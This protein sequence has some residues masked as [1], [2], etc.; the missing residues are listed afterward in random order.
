MQSLVA[1]L[2]AVVPWRARS[3]LRSGSRSS[4]AL[5]FAGKRSLVQSQVARLSVI[6]GKRRV[7]SEVLSRSSRRIVPLRKRTRRFLV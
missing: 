5:L 7:W 1:R 4:L 6:T 3:R 2:P